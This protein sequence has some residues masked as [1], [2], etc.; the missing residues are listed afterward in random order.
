MVLAQKYVA[1]VA[2]QDFPHQELMK[3]TNQWI[4]NHIFGDDKQLGLHILDAEKEKW[5]NQTP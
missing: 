1:G 2:R 4:L 3:K 5:R